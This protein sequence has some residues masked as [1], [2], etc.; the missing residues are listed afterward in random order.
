M[1]ENKF[2]KRMGHMTLGNWIQFFIRLLTNSVI[3]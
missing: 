1:V 3:L 2:L